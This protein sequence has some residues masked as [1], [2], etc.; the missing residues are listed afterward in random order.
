MRARLV[1]HGAGA[2][3]RQHALHEDD[4]A[5]ARPLVEEADSIEH[6]PSRDQVVGVSVVDRR[7]VARHHHRFL[8]VV[9]LSEQS[10]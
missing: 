10:Q 8:D 7:I 5:A 4:V 3:E 1:A 6:L 9:V 2:V